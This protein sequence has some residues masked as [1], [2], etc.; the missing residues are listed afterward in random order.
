M[1]EILFLLALASIS[2]GAVADNLTVTGAKV[3]K[4][5]VYEGINNSTEVWI[6]LNGS[7]RIGPN[8][9]NSS[10]TCELWTK[11]KNVLAVALAA[12]MS[13]QKIEAVY[14]DRGEGT[15]WC[16]VVSLSTLSN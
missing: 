13:G 12:Q 4:V 9:N 15:Y 10:Y 3:T 14:A 6:H 7:P 8:P 1:K 16:S 5:Q 2:T 11:N